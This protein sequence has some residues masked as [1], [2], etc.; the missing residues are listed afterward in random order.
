MFDATMAF[1][2]SAVVPYLV[3]GQALERT[4]NTGYSGQPTSAVFTA[5]D[6][7]YLSLGVVQQSQFELLARVLE[8]RQW[9]EDGRFA[10]PDA[11]R[12]NASAMQEE[13]SAVLRT[14]DAEDWE[15]LLSEAGIPC[16]MVRDIHEAM[17]LPELDARSLT[18]PMCI[19]GLPERE[20]VSVLDLGVRGSSD[21]DADLP[22]PPR[23]GEHTEE[24]RAWLD[25]S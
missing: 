8:Q 12:T 7:H 23:L 19:A 22:P 11:R 1:M 14:R 4:G 6:G 9:L 20:Q 13:L 24:I 3:T 17:S 21:V 2:S 16:G 18:V 15:A 5:R 10:D 25:Q